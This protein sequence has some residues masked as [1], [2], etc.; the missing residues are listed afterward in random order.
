MSAEYIRVGHL[1]FFDG[2]L[3]IRAEKKIFR[4]YKAQLAARSTVFM[5]MIES[6]TPEN[7]GDELIDGI[8]VVALHD[9]ADDVE[10]FLRA[11]FDSSYFMPAPDPANFADVLAILRI[12]HKYDVEYLHR[13]ALQHLSIDFYHASVHEYIDRLKGGHL[14]YPR[15]RN[16]GPTM[17]SILLT[18]AFALIDA[19]RE[20]GALW[21]LPRPY[22]VACQLNFEYLL[23]AAEKGANERHVRTCLGGCHYLTRA[24][25]RIHEFLSRPAA[26]NCLNPGQC[27]ESRRALWAILV[28]NWVHYEVRPFE[29][30][31]ADLWRTCQDIGFCAPCYEAGR[32]THK[33][34]L[35]DCWNEL[36]SYFGLPGWP[37]LNAMKEAAMGGGTPS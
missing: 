14:K 15:S 7:Q 4:V 27:Q 30:M 24:T 20:V 28:S 21:L 8:P 12:S 19:A 29:F 13:R 17:D 26:E 31:G 16:G 10:V 25:I 9:S 35:E 22:Y 1:W 5:A 34:A 18:R 33:A 23:S 32:R 37:E 6:G 3:V 2:S 36:P 11:I